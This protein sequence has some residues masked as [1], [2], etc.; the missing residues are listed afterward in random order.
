MITDEN[1]TK[2]LVIRMIRDGIVVSETGK[3]IPIQAD[4]VCVHSDSAVALQYAK[5]VRK[6][7]EEAQIQIVN[8]EQML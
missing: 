5:K 6:A 1:E 7:L 3:E 2:Q 4:S 8:M